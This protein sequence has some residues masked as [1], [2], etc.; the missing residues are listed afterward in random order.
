[1]VAVARAAVESWDV[2]AAAVDRAVLVTEVG[3]AEGADLAAAGG[4]DRAQW[5]LAHS[6]PR[7]ST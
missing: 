7:A 5:K 4:L 6:P 3:E 1:L 2:A